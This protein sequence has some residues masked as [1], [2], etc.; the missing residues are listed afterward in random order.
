MYALPGG[1][2]NINE[3]VFVKI[4]AFTHAPPGLCFDYIKNTAVYCLKSNLYHFVLEF[5]H[6]ER[7]P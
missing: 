1:K 7:S 2:I 5:L 6:F 3:P 4:G